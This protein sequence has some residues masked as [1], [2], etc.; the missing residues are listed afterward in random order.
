MCSVN[1]RW[2]YRRDFVV[3]YFDVQDLFSV[4]RKPLLVIKRWLQ[5]WP[6]IGKTIFYCTTTALRTCTRFLR[7]ANSISRD[8]QTT[9][10]VI[11][12]LQQLRPCT[13]PCWMSVIN[14]RITIIVRRHGNAYRL[15]NRDA[16]RRGT[17]RRIWTY[18]E[19]SI[20]QLI[21]VKTIL[22]YKH[23]QCVL[24][25]C[26]QHFFVSCFL[27]NIWSSNAAQHL[28]SLYST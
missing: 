12:D 14:N 27:H 11:P 28:C 2:R 18:I 6:F 10:D 23:Q 19:H 20:G 26:Q 1:W 24:I 9:R 16:T 25:R 13:K 5:K 22:N 3:Q 4:F 8:V 17:V 15:W 7:V 21:M